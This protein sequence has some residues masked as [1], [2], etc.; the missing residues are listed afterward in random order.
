MHNI[1]QNYWND[2]AQKHKSWMWL[3]EVQEGYENPEISE[4]WHM[5]QPII[6]QSIAT[7]IGLSMLYE[8]EIVQILMPY[9]YSS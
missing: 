8:A 5:H 3:A 2:D 7:Q 1:Q 4:F 6:Y 9:S